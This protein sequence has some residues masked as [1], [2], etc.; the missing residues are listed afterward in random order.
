MSLSPIDPEPASDEADRSPRDRGL[1]VG[2]VRRNFFSAGL[3]ALLLIYYGFFAFVLGTVEAYGAFEIG[4]RLFIHAMRIGG[5]VMA[6]VAVGSLLGQPILLLADALA[7]ILIGLCFVGGAILMSL[8]GGLD[9]I[10]LVAG[11]LFV[12]G[13]LRSGRLWAEL[14]AGG[15][16]GGQ[17]AGLDAGP[18]GD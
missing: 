17:T 13:G 15:G 12:V 9:L 1:I 6:M 2:L 14:D 8:E 10:V 16:G 5:V 18:V 7:S 11:V 3:A 4:E